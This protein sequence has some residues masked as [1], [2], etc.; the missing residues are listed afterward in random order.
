MNTSG[1]G[2]PPASRALATYKC[3]TC[4]FNYLS[5]Q[6]RLIQLEVGYGLQCPNCA[7]TS[8]VP[9]DPQ[10]LGLEP[11][12]EASRDQF[13][14]SISRDICDICL[15][16]I[17]NS[18]DALRNSSTL[19][20]G[21]IPPASSSFYLPDQI[22]RQTPGTPPVNA[23]GIIPPTSSSFYLPDEIIR[24]IPGYPP[25]NALDIIPPASSSFYLPD[26]II[27][28]IPGYPPVNALDIIPPV[29]SSFYQPDQR[30][31]QTPASPPA[32]SSFHQPEQRIQQNQGIS[33]FIRSSGSSETRLRFGLLISQLRGPGGARAKQ[34]GQN[35]EYQALLDQWTGY[36]NG[37]IFQR[38]LRCL[39]CFVLPQNSTK[40]PWC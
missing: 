2:V 21:T 12:H 28:Q 9:V 4:G 29:S 3:C 16:G 8:F 39:N 33:S 30:I 22:I 32:S 31:H 37:R 23:L 1:H 26:E 35:G 10:C 15:F 19:A 38:P 7:L 27:R 11:P 40:A 20:Q 5:T 14:A 36:V 24:Q 25:V 34:P 18:N 6:C 17:A 13:T